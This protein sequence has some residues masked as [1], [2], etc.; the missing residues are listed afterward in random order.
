MITLSQYI[1]NHNNNLKLSKEDKLHLLHLDNEYG[2]LCEEFWLEWDRT[3]CKNLDEEFEK[4]ISARKNGKK[5]FPQLEL[6]KDDLTEDWLVRANRLK[7]KFLSFNCFLSKYYIENLDHLYKQ[8]N[9]TVHKDDKQIL[10]EY[11]RVMCLPVSDKD[12]KFAWKLVKQHHYVDKRESQ[13]YRGKDVV[14]MMQSHMDK[15]GYGFNVELNPYMIARQNVEPHNKTLH[16]KTDGYF[17][18]LDV[19]SLR[20][21]EIDVHVAK[22]YY[23]FKT[24]L[25]LF[26]YGLQYCN[27]LDEG[28]AINQSLHHNKFGV[29]PNLQFDIAIKT[30]IGRH[31]ME[32]DFCELY[33]MLI[34]KI[35]TEQNK[36]IIESILFKNLCRF[37]RVLNDCSK[38]GG[39]GH[40]ETDY[41]CGYQM[42]KSMSEKRRDDIIKY[43]IGPAHIKDLPK[44]KRFLSVNKFESL[45]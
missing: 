14:S 29:K 19:E 43:N 35:T 7:T 26:V 31:I 27:K 9:M 41:L 1:N 11:N 25:N 42:V 39:D 36:D 18:D 24:G 34:D 33:D 2:K 22:R 30:I 3:D 28:M 17:S 20:I 38:M 40:G 44:I 15:R 5:Y 21:H 6:V 13:P 8:V 45:I 10:S 16:I 23:G 12:Y 32:K 37:K 4:F